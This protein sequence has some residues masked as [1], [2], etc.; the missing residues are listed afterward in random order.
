MCRQTSRGRKA[1]GGG[2]KA[3]GGG[4]IASRRPASTLHSPLSTLHSPL[5]TASSA[6][7]PPPSAFTL[8]ELLVVIAIIGIMMSLLIPAVQS[9]REAARRA[10]CI[11]YQRQLGL[12]IHQYEMTKHHL[13]GYV[14]QV[15]G[16]QESW[17]GVVLPFIGR[18]DLWEGTTALT[19]WRSGSTCTVGAPRVNEFVCPDDQEASSVNP[20]LTY[21]VNLGLYAVLPNLPDDPVNRPYTPGCVGT[22]EPPSPLNPQPADLQRGVFRDYYSYNPPTDTVISLSD[23]KTPARTVM[24]SEKINNWDST[25][26]RTRVW[27]KQLVNGAGNQTMTPPQYPL[28]RII[29]TN[30]WEYFG[31]SWPDPNPSLP[32][33]NLLAPI[34]VNVPLSALPLYN[35]RSNITT[36]HPGV[37]IITF[38]DGHV[39][40][41]S[42][43][44]LCSVYQASL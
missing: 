25:L 29:R 21:V 13:P 17:A 33:A 10:Q 30:V 7:R 43:D 27:N 41:I 24:L 19:G 34:T 20:L 16:T 1:E 40:S 12:G 38:A 42:D 6:L 28:S 37:V 14:N 39:D 15:S 2:R 36:P 32:N 22:L 18:N 23:V 44:T 31:F 9:A 35:T 26:T 11:N 3:E 4:R 8:V 5:P